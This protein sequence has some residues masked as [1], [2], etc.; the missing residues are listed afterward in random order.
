MRLIAHWTVPAVICLLSITGAPV[1]VGARG[2]VGG[3]VL[4]LTGYRTIVPAMTA[5]PV[6][7]ILEGRREAAIRSALAGLSIAS[8]SDCVEVLP[9]FS[10][11]GEHTDPGATW[12][13]DECPTPGV[14]EEVVDGKSIGAY[15]MDCALH[16]AV[17]KVLPKRAVAT[18]T[19]LAQTPCS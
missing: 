4:R 13:W 12:T 5:G 17:L 15:N 19:D 3:T 6:T 16:S 1:P 18:R 10:I 11:T 2:P 14:I 7:A 8:P 9:G